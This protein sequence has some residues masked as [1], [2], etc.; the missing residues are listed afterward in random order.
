MPKGC[1]VLG[2]VYLHE[3]G[4]NWPF[5][6]CDERERKTF[7]AQCSRYFRQIQHIYIY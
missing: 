4:R 2:Q 1:Y 7:K 6:M 5:L 3:G